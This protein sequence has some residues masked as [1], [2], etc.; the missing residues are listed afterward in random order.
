MTN[1]PTDFPSWYETLE[2]GIGGKAATRWNG[3]AKAIAE[4]KAGDEEALIRLAFKSARLKPEQAVANRIIESIRSGDPTFGTDAAEREIQ[5][6][7]ASALVVQL[8]T[9]TFAGLALT[10]ASME[11]ARKL[12]LPM[13]LIGMAE[14]SVSEHAKTTRARTKVK[15]IA[16]AI[17]DWSITEGQDTPTMLQ[18]FHTAVNKA[19]NLSTNRFNESLQQAKNQQELTDEELQMLWWLIGGHTASGQPIADLQ[20]DERPFIVGEELATRTVRHPGPLA[21]TALLSRASLE[22]KTKIKV[23]EAVNAMD[24]AWC[25]KIV[26]TLTISPVTHPIHEAIRRRNETGAGPNWVKNW[27]AVC[28]IHENHALSPLRLSELFYRERLLLTIPA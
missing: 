28:E 27:A 10:T 21:I 7:A 18:S 8:K 23:I 19:I 22:R 14:N 20:P 26:D 24:N 13:D 3:V 6:L 5:I 11:G 15:P 1:M 16:A 9:S 4:A 25:R 2:A 12:D 17:V